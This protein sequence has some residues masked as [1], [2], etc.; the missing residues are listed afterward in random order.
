MATVIRHNTFFQKEISL[1]SRPRAVTLPFQTEVADCLRHRHVYTRFNS[2][3]QRF[4][5][6]ADRIRVGQNVAIEPF[7]T[8]GSGRHFFTMG[9]FSYSWS[10]LPVNTLVG[11]YTSIGSRVRQMGHNH[12]LQRF[13][14]SSVSF[15]S[16]IQ[17][18]QDHLENER[19]DFQTVANPEATV[20]PVVIG[21]DVMVGDDVVFGNG[22][23][24]VSDGA[25]IAAGSLVTRDV[26]PY[27]VVAGW[28]AR[29]IKY[30]FDF[31]TIDDLLD[32]RWWQ[33]DFAKFHGVQAAG[34][35]KEF[36]SQV[37]TLVAQADLSTY[38]PQPLTTAMLQESLRES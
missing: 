4:S 14:T 7:T 10:Q 31:K 16:H 32:F 11:R 33:Y 18:Y 26:P 38:E 1:Q 34:P 35:I 20:K 2:A 3:D 37:A 28:P 6:N 30:R 21:N 9:A 24:V 27:A 5:L 29:V 23:I 12:P 17:A 25:V 8:F 15:D 36:I 22:G 19:S 13:T